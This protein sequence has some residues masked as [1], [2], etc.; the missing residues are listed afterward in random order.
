MKKSQIKLLC[1]AMLLGGVP[2]TGWSETPYDAPR[3]Q[4]DSFRV[5]GNTLLDP[6]D[7]KTAL[8][9]YE[10]KR[11]LEELKAAAAAVEALYVEA[12]YGGV[13]AYVPPQQGA[14]GVV[15]IIVLEGRISRV[16][17]LDNKR[18]P[19][20]VVL[21]SL[22]RLRVGAT[23][24][25]RRIDEQ[26]EMANQNPA[27]QVAVTLEPGASQGQ[28]E[29]RVSVSEAPERIWSFG[30]DNTG[31]RQ[32]GRSRANLGFFQGNLFGLDQSFQLGVQVA[33]EEITS[34]IAVS[35]A[36]HAPI[37]GAG[38]LLDILGGYSD[39]D[40]G[41]TGTAAG[42]LQFSGKS[43][44][45]GL[46][47]GKPLSRL[48]EFSQRVSI[49]FDYRA[50]INN[51][52][53]TGL[54]AGACGTAG[55][56]VEVTPASIDYQVQRGGRNPASVQLS[57]FANTAL[58]GGHAAQSDFTAARPGAKRYFQGERLNAQALNSLPWGAQLLVRA[59]GQA[60]R[61]ALVPGEQFGLAGANVVRG[62]EER[63]V[64]GDEA[65]LLSV[66]LRSPDT[67]GWARGW[68]DRLQWTAFT[69]AG[70]VWNHKGTPCR[71]GQTNCTLLS[72]GPGIRASKGSFQLKL[73]VATTLKPG[74]LTGKYDQY[75]H[76]QASYDFR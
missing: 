22:S 43:R 59:S 57:Y 73:D 70:R 35:A 31:N 61:S 1:A 28:I 74:N 18:D 42:P 36:W 26:I 8:A 60:S 16:V 9:P 5:S 7:I 75:A 46:R 66:E 65:A 51:C 19:E 14:T 62:Y 56:S 72:A 29:A 2:N 12:G 53:I 33:P 41:T 6:G 63:E 20:S 76:V 64:T 54:P 17:V 34:V 11:S 23:P 40:G 49:G 68:L 13:I 52:S 47:I 32:T 71:V 50:Y 24:Q 45:A 58:F 39:I 69:D 4:V 48:G 30:V 44:T 10:G 21:N 37:Y 67:S 27:R 25:P 3:V 55:A 38:L 15:D